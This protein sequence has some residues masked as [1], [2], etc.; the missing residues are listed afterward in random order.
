MIGSERVGEAEQLQGEILAVLH[1]QLSSEPPPCVS[2]QAFHHNNAVIEQVITFLP[3]AAR[4]NTCGSL[5]STLVEWKKSH[6]KLDVYHR[7]MVNT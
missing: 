5:L 7:V 2:R 6:K 3:L 1:T 4:L